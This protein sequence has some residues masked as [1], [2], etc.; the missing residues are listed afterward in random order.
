[1]PVSCDMF[2]L[3][4]GLCGLKHVSVGHPHERIQLPRSKTMERNLCIYS[5]MTECSPMPCSASACM[6]G[7]ICWRRSCMTPIPKSYCATQHQGMQDQ[8]TEGIREAGQQ[9]MLLDLCQAVAAKVWRKFSSRLAKVHPATSDPQPIMSKFE[10]P[11]TTVILAILILADTQEKQKRRTGCQQLS[12][13]HMLTNSEVSI[14]CLP[15]KKKPLTWTK[16]NIHGTHKYN[17]LRRKIKRRKAKV[18]RKYFF[19]ANMTDPG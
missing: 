2:A 14:L 10:W 18:W 17:V 11:A 7:C 4:V 12:R 9:E 6:T 3:Y 1:M 5:H 19:L 16:H 8:G 15:V 13:R